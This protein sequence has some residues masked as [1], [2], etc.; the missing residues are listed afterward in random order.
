MAKRKSGSTTV[1]NKRSKPEEAAQPAF[2]EE[3]IASL[4]EGVLENAKYNNLAELLDQVTAAQAVLAEKE[5]DVA[6]SACRLA[7]V[8]LYKC[9]RKLLAGELM[10]AEQKNDK[11]QLVANWLRD[12]YARFELVL[13]ALVTQKLAFQLSA[14]IDALDILLKLLKVQAQRD[15]T[16]PEESYTKIAALLLRSE[17]GDV[18]ADQTTSNFL[19]LEFMPKFRKYWDLQHHFF[20]VALAD[21]IGTWSGLGAARHAQIFANY[22]TI[23][24]E[25]TSYSEDPE[26]L[27]ELPVYTGIELDESAYG[28]KFTSLYQR[29]LVEVMRTTP[30][31]AA[32]YK[33]LLVILH[34]RVLPYL[35]VPAGLMD[36]LTDAYDQEEDRVVPILALSSLWELVRNYNLE[37]P[38]FY[39]KLYSLLTPEVLFT[40]YR[41]RFFR[42]CDLFLSLTHLAGNLVASFIKRLARLALVAPAP[43]VVIVIPFIYNLLKRHPTCMVLLQ[44]VVDGEYSDPYISTEEDP[45]K[46]NAMGLSLWEMETLMSHYHPNVATLAKMFGEPFRKPS[47]NMEDFL[48]W[49]YRALMES[50]TTRKYKGMASLEYEEYD[51]LMGDGDRVFVSGWVL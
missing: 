17:C 18:L 27:Q 47:Y 16:F 42:L 2:S 3:K 25:G 15:H 51:L 10:K 46:T 8:S 37:Y 23:I 20:S 28:T 4:T 40:R 44:N 38:D 32:Q 33:A 41:A 34:K 21:Q 19:V 31:T 36:F 48:E 26:E 29:C 9:F 5:S 6:E 12:K 1:K 14:Q 13:H 50:E 49:S 45:L 39:R 43:G 7:L 35:A 30:L 22:F 11:K 24:R